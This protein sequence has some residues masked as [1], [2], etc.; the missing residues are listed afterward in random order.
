MME[1]TNGQVAVKTGA[2]GV[3]CAILADA[4]V[5]VALKIDDGAKRAAEVAMA[6]VLE[7]LGVPGIPAGLARPTV[8][9]AA[10][11]VVGVIRSCLP[12]DVY[13]KAGF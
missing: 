6:A 3:H 11:E 9:N 8:L 10:G 5:G 2:E 7:R 1:A 12:P 4:G 13:R